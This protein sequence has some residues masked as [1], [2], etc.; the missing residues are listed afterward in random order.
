MSKQLRYNLFKQSSC[1]CQTVHEW[2]CVRTRWTDC[3]YMKRVVSISIL[4]LFLVMWQ[5]LSLYVC[6]ISP[7]IR[8]KR[9]EQPSRETAHYVYS[10]WFMKLKW[11]LLTLVK[12]CGPHPELSEIIFIFAES[13]ERVNS[14]FS[15]S[16]LIVCSSQQAEAFRG[17]GKGC[18]QV[19]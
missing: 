15:D 10:A 17:R 6:W 18:V 11:T 19:K 14:H 1:W 9:A 12:C 7:K 8:W 3:R 16:S 13:L 2:R 5:L 4:H